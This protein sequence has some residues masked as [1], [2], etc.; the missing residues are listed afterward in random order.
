MEAHAAKRFEKI[1]VEIGSVCNLQCDFCPPVERDGQ[2]MERALFERVI[3][4]A[5]PLAGRVCF[6]LMGEP[7]AHPEF[8]AFIEICAA[9]GLPVEIATNGT[10][11]DAA[12]SAA[13]LRPIVAQVN[14]SVHSF[15]A[16]FPGRDIG[17]Y[18][19]GIFAFTRRALQER[20][21]LY[22]NYRLWNLG[23]A[24]EGRNEDVI[25]RVEREFGVAVE[26]GVDVR[27]RK[28][29]RVLGR[30][31]LHFDT[32]FE[33]PRLDAPEASSTGTCRA[34]SAQV[35][36]LADGTV[37]PCCLDK[38]GATVLGNIRTRS[39]SAI[40]SGERARRML[41]GFARGRL[42]EDLCRRCTFV[43]RFD[44]QARRKAAGVTAASGSVGSRATA[45]GR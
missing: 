31:S 25:R 39:L 10:L 3:A 35:G 1:Y 34:L 33:W 19:N 21:E 13:L 23:G 26:R 15:A 40:T 8:A 4:E 32:R 27:R 12:R 41:E 44:A 28:S 17:P 37:V 9:R 18:L 24:D 42:V 16:N 2:R 45:S 5:A 43:A 29:R 20:P 7:L 22:V 30:L 11:L 6:H 14:F 36:I 38:E